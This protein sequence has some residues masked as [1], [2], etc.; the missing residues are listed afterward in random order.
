MKI[1][2]GLKSCLAYRKFCADVQRR[3]S[4]KNNVIG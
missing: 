4:P 2:L 3:E 1:D